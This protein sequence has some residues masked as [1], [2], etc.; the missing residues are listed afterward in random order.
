[1]N[2]LLFVLEILV[3]LAAIA[4]VP[5]RSELRSHRTSGIRDEHRSEKIARAWRNS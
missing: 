4:L 3:V 5:K 1:M 2:V